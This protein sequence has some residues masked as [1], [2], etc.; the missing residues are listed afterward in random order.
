[1]SWSPSRRG[2]P[3]VAPS[4]GVNTMATTSEAISVAVSVIG[5]YF[6]YSPVTSGQKISGRKTTMV[7]DSE[8]VIGHAMA[9]A[10]ARKASRFGSPSIILRSAYSTSTMAPSTSMPAARIRLNSTTTLMVR[11]ASDSARMPI[12]NEAGMAMPTMVPPRTPSAPMMT[13][14]TSRMAKIRL[15]CRSVSM[16]LMSLERSCE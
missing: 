1:M 11:P 2:L 15:F 8:L 12:R 10:A 6:M 16:S 7:T 9:L 14:I 4:T 5:R 3:K 13:I